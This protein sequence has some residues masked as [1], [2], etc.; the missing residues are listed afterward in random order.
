M[1]RLRH[2][3][4]LPQILKEINL[5][6]NQLDSIPPQIFRIKNLQKLYLDDNKIK[7]ISH[8][9]G[10]LKNLEFLSIVQNGLVSIPEEIKKLKLLTTFCCLYDNALDEASVEITQELGNIVQG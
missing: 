6:D 5:Y 9:V 10:E 4:S 8:D 2:W 1:H 7:T 3:R